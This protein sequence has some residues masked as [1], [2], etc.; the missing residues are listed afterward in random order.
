LGK[1]SPRTLWNRW[2]RIQGLGQLNDLV[3]ECDIP[4]AALEIYQIG[5]ELLAGSLVG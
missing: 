3:T 1:I 4:G 5:R 2:R